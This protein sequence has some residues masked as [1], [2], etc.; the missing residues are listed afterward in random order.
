MSTNRLD[1][2][3][4]PRRT[5]LQGALALGCGMLVPTV[6]SGCDSGKAPAPSTDYSSTPA[7]TEPT[8]EKVSQESVQ[9]QYQPK[10][11]QSCS[12]C[13]HFI[14]ESS[15]CMLVEGRINPNGWCTLWA[16]KA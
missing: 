1:E 14:A 3:N 8:T 16:R 10:G 5:V 6:L 15:T 4:L 9:Y 12:G 13:L 11:D 2:E 7:T